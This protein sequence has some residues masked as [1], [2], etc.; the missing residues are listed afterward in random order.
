MDLKT[1]FM[2]E[3]PRIQSKATS[4]FRIPI[5]IPT[6]NKLDAIAKFKQQQKEGERLLATVCDSDLAAKS[7]MEDDLMSHTMKEDK[8][9][10]IRMKKNCI[11][12]N[13]T[14]LQREQEDLR[15]SSNQIKNE[16]ASLNDVQGDLLWILKKASQF[17]IQR[18][19]SQR[20]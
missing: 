9:E 14:D 13:C 20:E 3:I 19:H 16:I 18:N 6:Q 2:R 15:L 17:E 4:S 12:E 10:E 7:N 11:T 5:N 8:I 1:A